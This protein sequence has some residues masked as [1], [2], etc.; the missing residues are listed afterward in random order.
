MERSSVARP[1][2]LRWS[3]GTVVLSGFPLLWVMERGAWADTPPPSGVDADGCLVWDESVRDTGA[4]PTGDGGAVAPHRVC[5]ELFE[6]SYDTFGRDR[7]DEA[8]VPVPGSPGCGELA[9]QRCRPKP[10]RVPSMKALPDP[11][12]TPPITTP[13]GACLDGQ[14]WSFETQ[15]GRAARLSRARERPVRRMETGTGT[16]RDRRRLSGMAVS[17][18]TA[19]RDRSTATTSAS[20]ASTRPATTATASRAAR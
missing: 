11:Y 10:K 2:A 3:I 7:P 14:G 20:I 17:A 19:V 18:A 12:G 5:I 1:Q 16:A 13:D 4:T 15:P 8:R 9:T 6:D